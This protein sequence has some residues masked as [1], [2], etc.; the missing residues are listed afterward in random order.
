MGSQLGI[1]SSLSS[2]FPFDLNVR[3]Y[4]HATDGEHFSVLALVMPSKH[5]TICRSL[6][7]DLV[8]LKGKGIYTH[9]IAL[10]P[11]AT[12]ISFDL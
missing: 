2:Y 11:Q 10:S 12:N 4:R 6:H 9:E 5:Q 8:I 7:F 1:V 3:T